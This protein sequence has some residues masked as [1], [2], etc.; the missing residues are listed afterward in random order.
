[1]IVFRTPADR[2]DERLYLRIPDALEALQLSDRVT[3]HRGDHAVPSP[4]LAGFR[5]V[6]S[7]GPTAT[8]IPSGNHFSPSPC[9][10]LVSCRTS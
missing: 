10:G 1:M 7:H 8:P 5:L 3:D 4:F 2:P 9:V 6:R